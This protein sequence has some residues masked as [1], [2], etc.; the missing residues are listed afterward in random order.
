[1]IRV[2]TLCWVCGVVL[3]A[4][5]CGGSSTQNQ[6]TENGE[7]AHAESMRGTQPVDNRCDA[8]AE[9][10][11]I[12]EYDTSGDE[13]PDVRKVFL[14]IG[15][16]PVTTLVMVC[17][18]SDV[19]GDGTRDVVRYYTDEGRPM[20]E[21]SDRN[22]NGVMDQILFYEEGRVVRMERD[23]T[24]NGM[25]DIK[26]FYEDGKPSRSERDMAG[27]STPTEWR[28]DRWEYYDDGRM[29]RMGTDLD[30]D[31]RVDRWDRDAGYEEERDEQRRQEEQAQDEAAA[32]EGAEGEDGAAGDEEPTAQLDR[33]ADTMVEPRGSVSARPT[34]SATRAAS[35]LRQRST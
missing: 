12:S 21:E 3:L 11:E 2:E 8:D 28:P 19:N 33:A 5:G 31:G 32:E 13:W 25:V 30:G 24:D 14:R 18:E 15:E 6:R 10:H 16:P 17:R 4:G 34:F 9:G 1:M 23:S 29:V 7:A 26:V 22:F 20:R 27:R 35:P